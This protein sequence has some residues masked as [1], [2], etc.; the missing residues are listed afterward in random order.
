MSPPEFDS[1]S[2]EQM[3]ATRYEQLARYEA[4]DKLIDMALDGQITM[5]EAKTAWESEVITYSGSNDGT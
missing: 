4:F 1:E 3:L 2:H 5:A